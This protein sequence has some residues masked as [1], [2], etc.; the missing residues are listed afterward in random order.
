M[1]VI[2]LVPE[3]P[4]FDAA[5]D[6]VA[7]VEL[8]PELLLALEALEPP[9]P[10]PLVPPLLLPDE[11]ATKRYATRVPKIAVRRDR[12]ALFMSSFDRR[13]RPYTP[14]RACRLFVANLVHGMAKAVEEPFV[15]GLRQWPLLVPCCSPIPHSGYLRG[16]T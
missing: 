13:Q 8:L 4:L 12:A 6:P 9:S 2:L 3:A 10:P 11:Q 5:P 15:D 14:D 16:T 1:L 7:E